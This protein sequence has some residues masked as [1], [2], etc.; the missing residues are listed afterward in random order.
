MK[1]F[2]II[3]KLGNG[4]YS[5]VFKVRRKADS[6]IY[7]L[8][9][10]KLKNL[11]EKE[12]QNSLNEIRI[13]A[14]IKSP[15]VIGYKEA[16]FTEEDKTLN[17]VMEY[18][19]SGDL[20]QKI[21]LFKK[22]KLFFE[23][24]DIWKIFIQ[25]T[26]G[27]KSLHDLNILHR[28]FKSANIFL[29][30]DGAAKIGDL[31]VSKILNKSLGQTQTGTPYYASPEV[32]NNSPYDCKSDIWS[33]GCILYE[34][35]TL[36][37]PFQADDFDGLYKK[38]IAG[39]YNKINA[40]YSE[41]MNEILKLLFKVNPKE[42]PTCDEILKLDLIKKRIEFFK[43]EAGLDLNDIDAL[44][45]NE[46]LKTIR[47]S[48]NLVGLKDKLPK[49]NYSLPKIK[50]NNLNQTKT[51]NN[52]NFHREALTTVDNNT[53]INLTNNIN[54]LNRKLNPFS[55]KINNKSSNSN[56][57]FLLK[58]IRLNSDPKQLNERSQSKKLYNLFSAPRYNI[59]ILKSKNIEEKKNII[60]NNKKKSNALNDKKIYD[61]YKLYLS[62][63]VRQFLSKN[64]RYKLPKININ[65]N[66]PS[67]GVK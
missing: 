16:F 37:P 5:E 24:K 17:L 27:L 4:A 36:N 57:I 40:R 13:L 9:K 63:E 60:S 43:A 62:K 67:S 65:K 50:D 2:E 8:K 46:L 58:K 21:K 59:N 49:P 7:A 25:I 20:Y 39:K 28:D 54:T 55:Y 22:K 48:K 51:I 1:N 45:D 19:D 29:F 32:W 35:L 30:E 33:L 6:K 11:K 64:K 26:R 42:R 52:N 14:S 61:T 56:N 10:V 41:D 53:N 23:E 66:S 3:N 34:M 47:I 12:K 18:A 15:F 38:V 31:N 44:D